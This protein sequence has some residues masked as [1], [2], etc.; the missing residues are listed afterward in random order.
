MHDGAGLRERELYAILRVLDEHRGNVAA[1]ARQLGV[2]RTTVYAKL[3]QLK[4]AGMAA[5]D[6]MSKT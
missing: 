3:R 2:S 6:W 4:Q 1:T 5:P